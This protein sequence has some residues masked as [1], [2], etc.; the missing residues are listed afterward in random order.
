VATLPGDSG[1]RRERVIIYPAPHQQKQSDQPGAWL[2][3]LLLFFS[4]RKR[5]L[6]QVLHRGVQSIENECSKLRK[7]EEASSSTAAYTDDAGS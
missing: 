5:R 1:A 4:E 2:I 6:E 7:I 3:A